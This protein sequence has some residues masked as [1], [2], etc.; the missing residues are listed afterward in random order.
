[1]AEA[2]PPDKQAL[3]D[4][5]F[6]SIVLFDNR[7]EQATW[8]ALDDGR[9]EVTLRSRIRKLRADGRGVET[10]APVDDWID[11]GVFGADGTALYFQKHHATEPEWSLSVVVASPPV[12]AG[13]DPYNKLIDRVPDDNVRA[14][15]RR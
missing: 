7:A 2:T 1:M 9:Y 12:R 3:L 11:V 15:A 13:I 4:D 5:L 10:E 14:V 6:R 8:R